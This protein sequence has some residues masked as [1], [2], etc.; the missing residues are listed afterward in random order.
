M[1]AS[2]YP[3][4]GTA[5]LPVAISFSMDG[6]L[7][8]TANSMDGSFIRSKL[9]TANIR[10]ND[11]SIFTVLNR[12]LTSGSSSLLLPRSSN[13]QSVAF[14]TWRLVCGTG[15]REEFLRP[16]EKRK[17]KKSNTVRYAV[18]RC[19]NICTN[20][21]YTWLTAK[22]LSL[23]DYLRSTKSEELSRVSRYLCLMNYFS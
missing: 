4:P 16:I 9:A 22:E 6:S 5:A 12:A 17:F 18:Y 8:A 23:R 13:P 11:M 1:S 10:S 20:E 2:S 21:N 14:Q 19:K 3:L 7:L 15:N